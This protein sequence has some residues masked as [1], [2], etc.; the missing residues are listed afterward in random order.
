MDGQRFRMLF[1]RVD[2]PDENYSRLYDQREIF[3]SSYLENSKG[4][5]Q[6]FDWLSLN[7]FF[8]VSRIESYN[9]IISERKKLKEKKKSLEK[10][11]E[12]MSNDAASCIMYL[13]NS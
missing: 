10:K 12:N 2:H 8:F 13:R 6:E 9:V 5:W 7:F 11:K 4:D 3:F 1:P